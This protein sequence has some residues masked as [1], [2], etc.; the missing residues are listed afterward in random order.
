MKVF[1]LAACAAVILVS[2]AAAQKPPRNGEGEMPPIGIQARPPWKPP[3]TPKD[4]FYLRTTRDP[5][6][7]TTAAFGFLGMLGALG[8][9]GAY[10]F[11][12]DSRQLHAPRRRQRWDV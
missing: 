4:D 3:E 10:R 7:E 8:A 2:P 9:V 12:R 11:L 1:A 6:A 5:G